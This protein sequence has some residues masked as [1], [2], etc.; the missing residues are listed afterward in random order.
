MTKSQDEKAFFSLLRA[1]LWPNHQPDAD[2]FGEQTDW[3]EIFILSMQQTVTGLVWDGMAK[4]PSEL[5]PPKAFKLKWYSYVLK[6]E[7]GNEQINGSVAEIIPAYQQSGLHPVLLKGAGLAALYP[8]PLH[9][10]A[11]D[12][13]IYVGETDYDKA[14]RVAQSIGYKMGSESTYH[15]HLDRGTMVVENH[16]KMVAIFSKP[17]QKEFLRQL[18]A[19]Y[20]SGAASVQINGVAIPVP[21]AQFNVLFVFLHMYK[22][23]IQMGVGLRQLCDWAILLNSTSVSSL[24][25]GGCKKGWEYLGLFLVEYLGLDAEKLPYYN[26]AMRTE[27]ELAKELILKDGNFGFNDVEFHTK[28]PKSYWAGKLFSMRYQANRWFKVLRIQ[29]SQAMSFLLIYRIQLSIE[30]IV[31]DRFGKS[32]SR[33]SM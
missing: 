5:Q 14:N 12:M 31:N 20:P 29:P 9:R 3:N 11:G 32:K 26:P 21:P 16:R 15:S 24:E 30:Q 33:V 27:M 4:L 1:G 13:D 7:Q 18:S 10:C 8:N 19:W 22:H 2:L 6:I 28:R 25:L 23:F 17:L